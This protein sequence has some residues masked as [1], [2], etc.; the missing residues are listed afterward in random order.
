MSMPSTMNAIVA[1]AD[2][3]A[4]ILAYKT[5]VPVPTPGPG[6]VL[7]RNRLAGINYI[8]T[9]MRSGL[10]PLPKPGIIGKEG[11]GTVVALG[12]GAESNPRGIRPGD[13]VVWLGDGGYAEYSV[14]PVQMVARLPP[15]NEVSEESVLASW[16]TGLTAVSFVDEAGGPVVAGDWALVH[17]AAGGAGTLFVQYLKSRGVRVIGTAG[18]PEKT[19]LVKANGADVVIDYRAEDWV[20]KTLEAT[21]GEGVRVV[22]DS[23]GKDTWDGSLKTLKRKGTIV[24]FGNASG[25]VPP[26]SPSYVPPYAFY[27]GKC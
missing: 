8:D 16:L 3:D 23:V 12:P 6:Q 11:A 5:D 14:P 20:K 2:G 19:A 27:F 17:A 9:Y 10:Y 7:V 4:S 22:Y 25:M 15:E 18:G 21:G 26:I 24:S 13:R 1:Q